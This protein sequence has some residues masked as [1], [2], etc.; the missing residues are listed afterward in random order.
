LD[1]K[2]KK[3]NSYDE[4][5]KKAVGEV[6]KTHEGKIMLR[7][8]SKFCGFTSTDSRWNP[9]SGELNPYAI[10]NNSAIRNVYLEIRQH[11]PEGLL[12]EIEYREEKKNANNDV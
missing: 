1:N 9:V 8:L 2:V 5:I 4:K 12:L 10:I 3:F 6:A 11:I 7:H